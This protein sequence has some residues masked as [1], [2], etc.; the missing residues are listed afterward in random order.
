MRAIYIIPCAAMIAGCKPDIDDRTSLVSEPRI[1]AV[2]SEPAEAAPQGSVTLT[3]LVVDR[4]GSLAS[5]PFDWAFCD[6]R[7]PLAEL[8]P[9]SPRCLQRAGDFFEPLG[10]GPQV[11][12]AVPQKACRQFGPEVPEAKKDEPTGRP[13]DPDPTGGYYQPVRVVIASAVGDLVGI[14]RTRLACGF[15]GPT[16]EQLADLKARTHLNVNPALDGVS[17]L[18]PDDAPEAINVVRAGERVPLTARW[19][20]CASDA[21]ACTGAEAY[22]S[23]DVA[24]QSVAARREAIRLSWFTTAG[25]FDEDHTGRAATDEATTSDNAW[26]APAVAGPA[27]VWVVVR[28]DRGGVGWRGFAFDVR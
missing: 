3:A 5:A 9:V 26:T 10:G 24:T 7:K 19:A 15:V 16:P 1:L 13:V 22:A 12:A 6:E 18:V 2:R 25:T 14:G 11:T 17:A 8:G 21:P 4:N 28:D 20:T 27:H 23:Y